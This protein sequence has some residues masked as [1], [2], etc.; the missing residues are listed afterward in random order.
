MNELTQILEQVKKKIPTSDEEKFSLDLMTE[1]D[2]G[3]VIKLNAAELAIILTCVY[4]WVRRD[5]GDFLTRQVVNKVKD[6]IKSQVSEKNVIKTREYF[7]MLG[8]KI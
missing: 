6:K 7:E 2:D 3:I 4:D 8:G 5:H 1:H